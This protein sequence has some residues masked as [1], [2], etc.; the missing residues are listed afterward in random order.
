MRL[1]VGEALVAARE[2][3][4]LLLDL[5]LLR[6]HP[7]LDL[8]HL[9]AAVGELGVDLRPELHRLLARLD[10]RLAAD[11]LRLALGILEQLVANPRGPS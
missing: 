2:L 7:L 11:R 5:L 9:L 4:E 6:E 1:A 3:D 10:L 8:E